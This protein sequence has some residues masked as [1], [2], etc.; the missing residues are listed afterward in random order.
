MPFDQ[1]A[2]A[3]VWPPFVNL[4]RFCER[5][6]EFCRGEWATVDQAP[7]RNGYSSSVLA[8][9]LIEAPILV[10]AALVYVYKRSHGAHA[11][12][13]A[14]IGRGKVEPVHRTPLAKGKRLVFDYLKHAAET[15]EALSRRI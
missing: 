13:R 12:V 1:W 3:K 6:P 15:E 5:I 14:H 11:A 8:R 9:R 7:G 2:T 4:A 10:K